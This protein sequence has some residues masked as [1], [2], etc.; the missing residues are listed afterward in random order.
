MP[1]MVVVPGGGGNRNAKNLPMDPDGRE[2]SHGLCDCC[3]DVGTCL[4]ATFFPCI[5][6]AQNRRRYESLNRGQPDPERGGSGFNGDCLMHGC[7]TCCF[8]IGCVLQI[9]LRGHLRSRYHIKGG[10]CGD[11]MVSWCCTPCGLTQ[12]ARELELEEASMG[13]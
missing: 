5:V 4:I 2:W 7:I 13:I 12:E 9:P 10:G 11:C 3:S 1:A 8:G 6:Y